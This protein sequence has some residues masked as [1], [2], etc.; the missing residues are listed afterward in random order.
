MSNIAIFVLGMHRSGTSALAGALH[1]L[2]VKLGDAMMPAAGG[3]NERGFWEHSD[4]VGVHDRMLAALN[5]S[6]DDVRRLPDS[7]W[8]D[9]TVRPFR[10]ELLGILRRDFSSAP[11]WALKDPRM[12]RLLPLWLEII[13]EVGFTPRFIHIHRHP[14][15]VSSSLERR[16]GFSRVKAMYLWLDH[17]LSAERSSRSFDRVFIGY[18]RLLEDTRATLQHVSNSLNYAWPRPVEDAMPDLHAFLAPGLRHHVAGEDASDAP[19]E[20]GDELVRD[21]YANLIAAAGGE[22]SATRDAFERLDARFDA[23]IGSLDP[24]FISHL[25]DVQKRQDHYRA[26]LDRIYSSMSW[27]MTRPMRGIAKLFKAMSKRAGM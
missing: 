1:R 13:E 5:S 14:L 7:W 10:T 6:W 9:D 26:E 23:R 17:N 27:R 22:T 19:A 2:G 21:T 25:G 4:I 8:Q 18:D 24:V 12:C 11:L 16:D 20:L 3:I 15:E